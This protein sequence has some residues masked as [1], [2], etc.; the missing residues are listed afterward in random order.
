VPIEFVQVAAL[1]TVL[2]IAIYI[3]GLIALCWPI[4]RRVTDDPSTAV[5]AASMVPRTVVAAQGVRIFVGFPLIAALCLL[6]VVSMARWEPA[7]FMRVSGTSLQE[8]SMVHVMF[9]ACVSVIMTLLFVTAVKRLSDEHLFDFFFTPLT[10][11]DPSPFRWV[12]IALSALGGAIGG[13][14]FLA[15]DQMSW[16]TVIVV[17]AVFFGSIALSSVPDAISIKPPL[18]AVKITEKDKDGTVKETYEGMLLSHSENH[19]YVFEAK[20]NILHMIPDESADVVSLE[21][22]VR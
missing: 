8:T 14:L 20:K 21:P 19:W 4:Y 7:I 10:S 1:V 18:P 15:A 16:K 9:L 17:S 12:S 13:W 22:G 11:S 5:F 6:T 3:V 2:G